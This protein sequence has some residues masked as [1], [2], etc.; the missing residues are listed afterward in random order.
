[1]TT[2]IHSNHGYLALVISRATGTFVSHHLKS[3]DRELAQEWARCLAQTCRVEL[4]HG[5]QLVGSFPPMLN[6]ATRDF[7][8]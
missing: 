8:A 1:M 7:H 5:D 3:E 4:W 6:R 2:H